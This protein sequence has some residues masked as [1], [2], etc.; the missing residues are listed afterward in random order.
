MEM[1]R[2]GFVQ[3]ERLRVLFEQVL[4]NLYRWPAIDPNAFRRNLE[5]VLERARL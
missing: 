3:P 1:I 4:P 5:T 2:R